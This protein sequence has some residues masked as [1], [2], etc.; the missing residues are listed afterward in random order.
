[1]TIRTRVGLSNAAIFLFSLV[2]MSGVLYYEMSVEPRAVAKAGLPKEPLGEELFEVVLFYGIPTA[3]ALALAGWW[4]VRRALS[5]L[6]HLADAAERIHAN[7]L[8]EPVP[9]SGKRDELDRLCVVID[10]MTTRLQGSFESMRDFTLHASHELRTPLTVLQGETETMLNDAGTSPAQREVLAGQLDE[11]QRL[12]QIVEGLAFLSKADAGLVTLCSEAVRLDDLVRD[13]YADAQVLAQPAGVTVQLS[14]CEELT[15]QGDRHRLR[16]LLLNLIDNAITYNQIGG[17]VTMSLRREDSFAKLEI[18]NTGPGIAPGQLSRVFE[19]FFRGD[20]ARRARTEG[21]GLGLCISQWIVHTHKGNLS[22][23][24]EAGLT[25]TATVLLP[26]QSDA[27]RNPLD[28]S[29]DPEAVEH[30]SCDGAV[31]ETAEVCEAAGGTF[32][33]N[34]PSERRASVAR[35]GRIPG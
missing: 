34:A 29:R 32:G 28:P 23:R 19:R 26:I 10:A 27:S 21:C 15:I 6:D 13:G 4:L 25:T 14:R 3:I 8:N 35:A 7:N 33:N 11:I 2:L 30:T 18:V 1:M 5:P 24:S 17:S 9:R 16:Q 20:A 22:L 12:G 31:S